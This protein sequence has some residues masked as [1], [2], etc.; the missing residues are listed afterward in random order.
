M[1]DV[2]LAAADG[3]ARFGPLPDWALPP[4]SARSADSELAVRARVVRAL[5]RLP[6]GGSIAPLISALDDGSRSVRLE[7]ARALEELGR[8][9][10]TA[11]GAAHR[12]A[13][14]LYEEDDPYVAYAAYWALGWQGGSAMNARRAAFRDSEWGQTVWNIVTSP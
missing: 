9:A 5:G 11:V 7:A 10:I 3:L 1:W 12:L 2:R 6:S 4:L 8:G 13:L 14:L